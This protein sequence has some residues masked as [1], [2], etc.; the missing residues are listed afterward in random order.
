MRI[1]GRGHGAERDAVEAVGEGDDVVPA[2]DVAGELQRRLD[3]I[4]ARGA[5]ELDDI[6]HVARLEDRPVQSVEEALLGGRVQI[7]AVGDAV[8][9]DIFDQLLAQRRVVVAVVQAARARQE[10]EIGFALLIIDM[11]ALGAIEDHGKRPRIGLH[12][13]FE[14]LEDFERSVLVS[15]RLVGGHDVF[16]G[17]AWLT[18]LGKTCQG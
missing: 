17:M 18:V 9:F 3:G 16:S 4:R 10:I 5:G 1:A 14:I 13:G 8:V 2:L 6:A 7:E 15:R 12:V 11:G